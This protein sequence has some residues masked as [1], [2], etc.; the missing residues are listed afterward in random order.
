M[1]LKKI[2]ILLESFVGK[3]MLYKN[4]RLDLVMQIPIYSL[5]STITKQAIWQDASNIINKKIPALQ[6]QV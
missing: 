6:R 5:L 4:Y 2:Y 1:R 3:Y